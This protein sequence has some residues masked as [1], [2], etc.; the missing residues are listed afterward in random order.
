M[1]MA[2][3]LSTE[4]TKMQRVNNQDQLNN[5]LNEMYSLE[6]DDARGWTLLSRHLLLTEEIILSNNH[7]EEVQQARIGYV[8][9]YVVPEEE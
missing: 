9:P 8:E 7:H 1:E 5:L 2:K 6:H 4:W 3:K